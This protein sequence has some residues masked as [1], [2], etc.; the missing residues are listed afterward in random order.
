MPGVPQQA[1]ALADRVLERMR[2]GGLRVDDAYA[3][4]CSWTLGALLQLIAAV[5]IEREREK[6]PRRGAA[7]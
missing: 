7:R 3:V 1:S 6:R 2:E 5:V 4:S